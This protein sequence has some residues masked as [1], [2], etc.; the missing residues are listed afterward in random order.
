MRAETDT[1]LKRF[2]STG[3]FGQ[4]LHI[5][6][7]TPLDRQ[8]VIRMN[9]DT[10]YSAVVLDLAAGPATISKPASAGRFQSLLERVAEFS[11]MGLILLPLVA[12]AELNHALG[13]GVL[14]GMF[15]RPQSGAHHG[16]D[17]ESAGRP[18]LPLAA[19][20][21]RDRQNESAF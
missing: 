12:S 16:A 9:R 13:P 10:L 19:V 17:T 6:Q 8:D 14:G 3:G 11:L 4:F 18:N 1:T 20:D 7:P 5:R 2:A 15:L 21:K